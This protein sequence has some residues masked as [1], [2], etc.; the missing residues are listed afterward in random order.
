MQHYKNLVLIG[1]SH[2][3]ERSIR[4]IER[5]F[6]L[7]QP[8]IVAVELDRN[9]L[10]AL[11][12]DAK[13]NYSLSLMKE[14]GVTGYLFVL[15]G[16]LVQRK[17]GNLVGVVPGSELKR[18]VELARDNSKRVAL[19]DQD[20]RVTLKRFSKEFCFREKMRLFLDVFRG[21][22]MKEAKFDLR[23]VPEKQVIRKLLSFIKKRYPGFYKALITERNE[24]MAARLAAIMKNHPDEKILAVVGAGHEEEMMEIIR[25]RLSTETL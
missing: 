11:L 15:I 9:R 21:P 6:H 5:E 22:F 19:I 8:G 7:S 16:G 24:Y 20:V 3:S 17:L 25:K 4:E 10:K 2:I 13:P 18:A 12:E 23:G 1:T 14:V